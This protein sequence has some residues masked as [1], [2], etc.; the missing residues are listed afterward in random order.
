MLKQL[1]SDEASLRESAKR[2][3]Y[4]PA[5]AVGDL[6]FVSGLIGRSADGLVPD[7]VEEQTALVMDQLLAVLAEAGLTLKNLA[8]ITTY[9][10]DVSEISDFA[11][12]RSGYLDPDTPPAWTAVGVAALGHP[13][14]KFEL[15]AIAAR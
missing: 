3:N 1:L 11:V 2:F 13:Q 15:Q 5:V 12:A 14:A 9:H 10:V 7:T 8:S 6:V 4:S